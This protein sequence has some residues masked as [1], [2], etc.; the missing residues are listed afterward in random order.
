[1]LE[2]IRPGLAE[3]ADDAG[4]AVVMLRH[5]PVDREVFAGTRGRANVAVGLALA[6][7][8]H[9]VILI[10]ALA[11]ASDPFGAGGTD[12][13][14]VSVEV[15]LVPASALESRASRATEAVASAAII[16]QLEGVAAAAALEAPSVPDAA[17][18]PQPEDEARKETPPIE[19]AEAPVAEPP[20]ASLPELALTDT[21]QP[22]PEPDAVTLPAR[23]PK[24]EPQQREQFKPVPP[25]PSTAAVAA[26][27]GGATSHAT[28]GVN[29]RSQAAAAA[30]A[31]SIRAFTKG[32]VDA[33]GRTRPKGLRHKAR[34]TAKVAFAIAEGGGLEFVRVAK[35]SGY[36]VL[37]DAAV[38]AVRK[39]T[40][41]VP[42]AGMTLAQ[43]TYEVPYHFR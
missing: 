32:V 3:P 20:S 6:L 22:P 5:D 17:E 30:S 9:G 42:P 28:D 23:E 14:A 15:A 7:G 12:L 27:T 39:A 25:P 33:L 37:D 24:L 10:A 13:E 43:R 41:P 38:T 18:Q 36:G 21:N 8:L 2:A 34:G 16:D 31:G 35:S 1:M 26:E 19:P 40:F 29:R 11:G 4:R